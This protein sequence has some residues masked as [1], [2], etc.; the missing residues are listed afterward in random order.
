MRKIHDDHAL[1]NASIVDA[2]GEPSK[3]VPPPSPMSSV[4]PDLID[5]WEKSFRTKWSSRWAMLIGDLVEE[6]LT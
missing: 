2:P 3:L 6:E 1:R 5:R 4:S